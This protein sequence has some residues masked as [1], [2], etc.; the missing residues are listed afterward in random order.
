MSE[1]GVMPWHF[2]GEERLTYGEAIAIFKYDKK[3]REAEDK[4]A[5]SGRN[6]RR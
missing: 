6:K 5:K 2:G 3:R 1:Y 4:Q